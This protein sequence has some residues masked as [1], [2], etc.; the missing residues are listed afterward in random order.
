MPAEGTGLIHVL[1]GVVPPAE[2]TG[3][4]HVL[5]GV[6]LVV[7]VSNQD[8]MSELDHAV[9][10]WRRSLPPSRAPPWPSHCSATATA[11]SR[12]P[13]PPLITSNLSEKD[14]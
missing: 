3:L 4:I 9:I 5:G 8:F 1:G 13:R 11:D 7:A 12:P 6:V 2:G 10:F 14:L